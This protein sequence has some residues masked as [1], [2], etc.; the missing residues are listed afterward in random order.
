[1]AQ[2][3][4]TAANPYQTIGSTLRTALASILAALD[5]HTLGALAAETLPDTAG[6]WRLFP[7]VNSSVAL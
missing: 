3:G 2:D 1:M 7:T 4:R 5:A 6:G